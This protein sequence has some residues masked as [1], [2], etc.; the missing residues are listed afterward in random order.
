MRCCRSCAAGQAWAVPP[1]KTG[2]Q[3]ARSGRRQ[4]QSWGPTQRIHPCTPPPPLLRPAPVPVCYDGHHPVLAASHVVLHRHLGVGLPPDLH[5]GL[6]PLHPAPATL[7]NHLRCGASAPAC[8]C[9]Q[10]APCSTTCT[11]ENYKSGRTQQERTLPISPPAMLRGHSKRSRVCCGSSVACCLTLP[12]CSGGGAQQ[13][14]RAG[15][16][17]LLKQSCGAPPGSGASGQCGAPE[18]RTCRLLLVS[19]AP[20]VGACS[21]ASLGVSAG[22]V[23]SLTCAQSGQERRSMPALSHEGLQVR[24]AHLLRRVLPGICGRGALLLLL[25]AHAARC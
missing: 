3:A 8:D 23:S 1:N 4:A 2:A 20:W 6:T 9:A 22:P 17:G 18:R 16:W 5:D 13:G 12:F 7:R 11:P 10:P 24:A 21:L 14:S 19:E 15:Q 25:L